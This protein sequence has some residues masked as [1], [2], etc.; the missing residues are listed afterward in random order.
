MTGLGAGMS[1]QRIVVASREIPEGAVIDRLA[2]T[3]A[4]WP[5]ATVPAGAFS[6]IDSVVGRITRVAV[7][8][9]DPIVPARLAPAGSGPGLEV[10]IAPG[11]RPRR[12]PRPAADRCGGAAAGGQGFHGEHARPVRRPPGGA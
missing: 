11:K 3:A 4:A 12:P 10:K 7:F 2:V 8:S 5:R 1:T 9:G 6:S